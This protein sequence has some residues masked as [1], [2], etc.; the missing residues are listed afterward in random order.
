MT[1]S[2]SK[3][4]NATVYAKN[5][6]NNYIAANRDC[7]DPN[8][9]WHPSP[10]LFKYILAP[11]IPYFP[12]IVVE[13]FIWKFHAIP[14]LNLYGVLLRSRLYHSKED[15]SRSF[16]DSKIDEWILLNEKWLR[17]EALPDW[18]YGMVTLEDAN[19]VFPRSTLNDDLS[20]RLVFRPNALPGYEI[21]CHA[22]EPHVGIQPSTVAFKRNF[23]HLTHG[24]LNSV[25][26]NNVVV[27]GGIVLGALNVDLSNTIYAGPEYDSGKWTSSDVD[28]YIY[29]LS[30]INANKKILHIFDVFR[31][32]L[33]PGMRTLVI[34]NS[35]TITFYAEYPLRRIQIVLK[36]VNSPKDVL[37]NFDLDVCAMAWDGTHLWMLPRAARALETGCN[38]FTMELIRGDYLS[39]RR[40]SQPHRIVKYASRGYGL[41][42]LPSYI[43]HL[44]QFFELDEAMILA[45]ISF[46]ERK[47]CTWIQEPNNFS[48]ST[49]EGQVHLTGFVAF[50]HRI[51]I[52]FRELDDP[53]LPVQESDLMTTSYDV[54]LTL[55]Y[56][57]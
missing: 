7:N 9:Q 25:D 13:S 10:F 30:P 46:L 48:E 19:I 34:R 50:L 2:S 17:N 49:A 55:E 40:A 6:V 52:K 20:A 53:S 31:S 16:S 56:I 26:W 11:I 21:L 22:R 5:V 33:P 28:V 3:W 43:S 14:Y 57:N 42:I 37:L 29:G 41:R 27:A 23:V 12:A 47:S 35:R 45:Y 32:N 15:Y 1:S 18:R 44:G 51:Q 39:D 4:G 38:T 8:A 36:A 24:L 54:T